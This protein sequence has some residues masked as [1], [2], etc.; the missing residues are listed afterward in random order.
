MAAESA[1][2]ASGIGLS[3]AS[4]SAPGLKTAYPA[5]LAGGQ[6][7]FQRTA[8]TAAARELSAG[9]TIF[10]GSAFLLTPTPKKGNIISSHVMLP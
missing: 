4:R 9:L 8:L 3:R 7:R 1:D 5:A 6:Y 2:C 10:L